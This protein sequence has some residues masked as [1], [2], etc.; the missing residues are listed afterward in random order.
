MPLS[1]LYKYGLDLVNRGLIPKAGWTLVPVS[2]ALVI[3]A[4]G[5]LVRISD[6][7]ETVQ[8][9]KKQVVRKLTMSVPYR[10][11][12]TNAITPFFL[13]D[14]ATYLLGIDRDG[15]KANGMEK[16]NAC[17]KLHNEVLDGL[18]FEKA[19]A[20]KRFFAAWHPDKF[21]DIPGVE[22]SKEDILL[23]NLAFAFEDGSFA[24]ENAAMGRAWVQHFEQMLAGE[25]AAYGQCLITGEKNVPLSRLHPVVT[26][27]QYVRGTGSY[28]VSFGSQFSVSAYNYFDKQ[29]GMN[30]PVSAAAAITYGSA[31]K[32]LFQNRK[33]YQII[34]DMCLL[35]WAEEDDC[36]DTASAVFSMSVF[37]RQEVI[38][39]SEADEALF[40]AVRAIS[41]G[42][43]SAEGFAS[44]SES[45]S[46]KVHVMGFISHA[47]R[48]A[49]VF[50]HEQPLSDF[51]QCI[52]EHYRR[53]DIIRTKDGAGEICSFGYYELAMSLADRSEKVRLPPSMENDLLNAILQGGA[54]PPAMLALALRRIQRDGKISTARVALLKAF[55]LRNSTNM[56]AREAATVSLNPNNNEPAYLIGQLFWHLESLQRAAMGPVGKT[57]KDSYFTGASTRPGQV[58]AAF[59]GKS[60]YHLKKLYRSNGG[61]AYYYEKL[62]AQLMSRLPSSL[63]VQLSREEQATFILGYYHA[64]EDSF[65]S[66]KEQSEQSGATRDPSS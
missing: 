5:E 36:E 61:L 34:G 3:N 48:L 44:L 58:F 18:H 51:V 29:Q 26:S 6:L 65:C 15:K 28:L 12:H 25:G 8:L 19:T 59:T 10:D 30:A 64:K 53:T 35:F 20:I 45:L 24:T 62:I 21:E 2:F 11:K 1:A 39:D 66:K 13:A 56:M 41:F 60:N 37:G 50:H 23:G 17:A 22:E 33:H 47:A 9:G 7:R 16:L 63:P 14:N 46:K 54:Y 40:H 4:E 52:E 49:L 38:Y 57:I 27:A 32:Y 31:L 55:L 42:S 43:P